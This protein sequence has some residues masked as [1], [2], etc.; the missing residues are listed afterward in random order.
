MHIPPFYSNEMHGSVHS[1][2]LFSPLFDEY[3]VDLVVCGHT[4]VY[5]VHPPV[6]GKHNYPIIIGGGPAP[7][8]RTLMK[9]KANSRQ[10]HVQ[11]LDDAGKEVGRYTVT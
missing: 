2:E 10:L 6:K 7:G 5:G 8:T 1:R 3:K 4:H 9:I 11:M